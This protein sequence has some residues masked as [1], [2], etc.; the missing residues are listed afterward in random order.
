MAVLTFFIRLGPRLRR[1]VMV[2]SSHAERER[3]RERERGREG[4]RR[5]RRRRRNTEKKMKPLF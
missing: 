3:E 4:E 2:D 1:K 5:R